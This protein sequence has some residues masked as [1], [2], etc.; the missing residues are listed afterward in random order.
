MLTIFLGIKDY[1]KDCWHD[2]VLVPR[3]RREE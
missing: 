3:W 2:Y 1:V